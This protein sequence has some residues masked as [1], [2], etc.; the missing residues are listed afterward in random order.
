[1]VHAPSAAAPEASAVLFKNLR[2]DDFKLASTTVCLFLKMVS[3]ISTKGCLWPELHEKVK[4][5]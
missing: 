3:Q 2:L 4:N 5:L 1:M